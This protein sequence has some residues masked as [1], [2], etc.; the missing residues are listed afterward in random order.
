MATATN[1]SASLRGRLPFDLTVAVALDSYRVCSNG[2]CSKMAKCFFG[3]LPEAE[4]AWETSERPRFGVGLL[5]ARYRSAFVAHQNISGSEQQRAKPAAS[6]A[7]T[8]GEAPATN[9][10]H[11][12]AQR[13]TGSLPSGAEAR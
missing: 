10:P 11:V 13:P 6:L 2:V 7:L 5:R 9:L 1:P 4:G 3:R 8:F 12:L